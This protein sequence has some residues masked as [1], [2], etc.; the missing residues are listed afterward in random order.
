MKNFE[1]P[2]MSQCQTWGSPWPDCA[3]TDSEASLALRARAAEAS[4]TDV[5]LLVRW[6]AGLA[7]ATL[8]M[9]AR[10][11]SGRGWRMWQSQVGRGRDGSSRNQSPAAIK[12]NVNESGHALLLAFSRPPHRCRRHR[13]VSH[14]PASRLSLSGWPLRRAA[15][16]PDSKYQVPPEGLATS[17]THATLLS[18]SDSPSVMSLLIRRPCFPRASRG[19]SS[20][21]ANASPCNWRLEAPVEPA[22]TLRLSPPPALLQQM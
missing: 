13:S 8:A 9:A 20:L 18:D 10:P 16:T 21:P 14:L 17:R 4:E 7:L 15:S 1:Q 11:S 5:R 6:D 22:C 3:G 19:F 2:L 12:L